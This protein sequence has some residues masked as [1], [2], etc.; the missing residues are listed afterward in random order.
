MVPVGNVDFDKFEEDFQ[1]L[2]ETDMQ[3]DSDSNDSYQ[4]IDNPTNLFATTPGDT[5]KPKREKQKTPEKEKEKK[6][7][8]KQELVVVEQDLSDLSDHHSESPDKES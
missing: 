6:P 8:K 5:P 4:T 2:D 3:D 1:V 7:P